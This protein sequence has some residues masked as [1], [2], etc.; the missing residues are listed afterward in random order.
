MRPAEFR[1]ALFVFILQHTVSSRF[2]SL[3]ARAALIAPT[4][5]LMIAFG[6]GVTIHRSS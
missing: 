1:G 6:S 3:R 4:P 5:G 2:V